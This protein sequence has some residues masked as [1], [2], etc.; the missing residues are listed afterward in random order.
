VADAMLRVRL[1]MSVCVCVHVC[2]TCVCV[3]VCMCL[4]TQLTVNYLR[5]V[6]SFNSEYG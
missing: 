4:F 2:F 6:V 1:C 3:C 5:V